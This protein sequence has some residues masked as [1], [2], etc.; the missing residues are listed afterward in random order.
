M[1]NLERYIFHQTG[2][3]NVYYFTLKMPQQELSEVGMIAH[4][5]DHN[6]CTP[7]PLQFHRKKEN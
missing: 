5:P 2:G 1:W 7:C 3:K 4:K 6:S